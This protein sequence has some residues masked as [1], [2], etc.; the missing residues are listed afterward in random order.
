MDEL[1]DLHKNQTNICGYNYERWDEGWD[2]T[3]IC[4]YH[5]ERWDEGWDLLKLA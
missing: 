4:G 5:H 1:E 3:N 2:R